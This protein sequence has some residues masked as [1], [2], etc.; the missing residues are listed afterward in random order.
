[1]VADS[2]STQTLVPPVRLEFDGAEEIDGG[3]VNEEVP[4]KEIGAVNDEVPD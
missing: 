3:E 4:E 2:H 1:M